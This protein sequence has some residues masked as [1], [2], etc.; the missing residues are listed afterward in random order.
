MKSEACRVGDHL[1]CD[2]VARLSQAVK[3]ST[4]LV[5]WIVSFRRLTL[6]LKTEIQGAITNGREQG[7]G[8]AS[9]DEVSTPR[10][11]R[12]RHAANTDRLRRDTCAS[13]ALE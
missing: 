7:Q 5:V 1:D 2:G 6:K 4:P 10:T 8:A 13:V 12:D 11:R 9:K 3:H